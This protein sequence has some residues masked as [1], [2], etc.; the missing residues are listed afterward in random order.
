VEVAGTLHTPL[1]LRKH[2]LPVLNRRARLHERDGRI[3]GTTGKLSLPPLRGTDFGLD[4]E[5]AL[6]IATHRAGV[7]AWRGAPVVERGLWATQAGTVPVYRATLPSLRPLGTFEIVVDAA[8][9]TVLD[10]GN[11]LRHVTGSGLVHR[12]NPISTPSTEMLPLW[13]LDA[14][15][16]LKGRFVQVF[17]T[18]GVEAFRPDHVFAF[19]PL[20]PRFVQTAVYRGLTN[21]ARYAEA[22]GV[23]FPLEIP[24]FTNLV[25]SQTGGEFNNAF[26]DPFFPIFGFGNGDGV[27]T[28]NIG[29]DAD[30]AAHE[31]GHHLFD[32]LVTPLAS[33]SLA[34]LASLNEGVADTLAALVAAD[35]EIGEATLPG[36]PFLRNVDNSRIFPDDSS[37]SPHQTGL[38][39]A[40]LHWDL[41]ESLGT[42]TLARILFAGLPHVPPDFS[43]PAE[44]RDA[45]IQGD[46]AVTGG[47]HANLIRALAQ[48][49]GLAFFEEGGFEGFLSEGSPETRFLANGDFHLW[50]FNEFPGSRGLQFTTTGN[51]DV[52]LI[53]AP[54][55]NVDSFLLSDLIGTSNELV[56]VTQAT[57]PSVD[58]DDTWLLAVEAFAN[59]TYTLGVTSTLPLPTI[60][61]GFPFNDRL[62]EAGEVDLFLFTGFVGQ[63][64]RLEV[65][66]LSEDLDLVAVIFQPITNEVLGA[67]DDSG[68]GVDPL[69]Q[70]AF[71]QQFDNYAIAV[72][73]LFSDVDPTVG[74]GDYR[75]DLSLCSN[76]GPDLDGDGFVDV[77][78]DDDDDDGFP[79]GLDAAPG[80]DLG[81]QDVEGD[82]CDDCSQGSFDPFDDGLDSDGD[83]LCDAG[84]PDDD[85]DGCLD[86][87]DSSPLSPSVDEDQDFVGLDCDNCPD[88]FNPDQL[89]FDSDGLGDVCDPT[90][91]PEPGKSI[92]LFTA[93][94]AIALLG[95][96]RAL[97]PESPPARKHAL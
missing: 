80:S 10:R 35:P 71:V 52:D 47:S 90:P 92:G 77:C 20:D 66:A 53:V 45:L 23:V 91:M 57:A 11:R 33:D 31:F 25:D 69:I 2:G 8:D 82:S 16:F 14:S 34:E 17:D 9:G 65:T 73:T 83:A 36:Q 41:V 51:G 54:L 28:A 95:R 13:D 44:Y 79:D 27:L 42:D 88:D 63:V 37:A 32:T 93:L 87:V 86:G 7:R 75:I 39:F 19:S 78:D 56:Q 21:A 38:I 97:E 24:A 46:L 67:D 48:Q 62:D 59:S 61:A 18:R 68:P 12:E 94:L 50:L 85:N 26:Y 1:T 55:S 22:R 3:V 72:F 58:D 29:L 89:D 84:D 43:D 15:G 81:C 60:F 76:F 4:P 6:A 30:V 49:R 5:R 64:L 70:G 40:G 96:L 74:T